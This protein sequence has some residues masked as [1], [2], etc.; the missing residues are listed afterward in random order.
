MVGTC[1][2][3][4][5]QTKRMPDIIVETIFAFFHLVCTKKADNED[6]DQGLGCVAPRGWSKYTTNIDET[7]R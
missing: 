4:G 2:T 5:K 6:F 7:R 1:S 3:V